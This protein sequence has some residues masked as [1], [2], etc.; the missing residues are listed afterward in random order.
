MREVFV[1]D[2]SSTR[3]VRVLARGDYFGEV[4]LMADQPRSATVQAIDELDLYVLDKTSFHA[5]IAAIATAA[6]VS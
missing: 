2:G 1:A 3:R 4:A 5:A 6:A